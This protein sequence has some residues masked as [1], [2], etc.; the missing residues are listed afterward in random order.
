MIGYE[1]KD[2][3][4]GEVFYLNFEQALRLLLKAC[5]LQIATTSSV[6]ISISVDGADVLHN[7]THVSTGVKITH[8]RG[9]HPL[10]NQPLLVLDEDGR[11]KLV[12]IQSSEMCCI[13]II[14]DARDS[15]DLY[16]DVFKD[17][18]RWGERLRMEG[19]LQSEHGPALQ[20]FNLTHNADM[21]AAWVLSSK[22]GGCKTKEFFCTLCPCT[23]HTLASY[24]VLN[25]HCDRCK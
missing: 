11:D 20:P 1:R 22:G 13:F 18:Y 23:K 14:A 2:T 8:P 12:K 10:T 6:Q 24:K 17:F 15:K 16:E 4:Y 7:R 5:G 25:D 19:L 21:K 9:K 3:K